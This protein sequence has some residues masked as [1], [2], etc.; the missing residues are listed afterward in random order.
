MMAVVGKKYAF[1]FM[2]SSLTHSLARRLVFE[3]RFKFIYKS[4]KFKIQDDIPNVN[5]VPNNVTICDKSYDGR[6][7]GSG[8]KESKNRSSF[9]LCVLLGCGWRNTFKNIERNRR[10]EG[11]REE[12]PAKNCNI[13][14]NSTTLDKVIVLIFQDD[15]ALVIAMICIVVL[16]C[17]IVVTKVC[18]LKISH[19][20]FHWN[21]IFRFMFWTLWQI[22]TFP[23]SVLWISKS[24]A[25]S[26]TMGM[27]IF[28]AMDLFPVSLHSCL[29]LN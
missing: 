28:L 4:V 5:S 9:Y 27:D 15:I 6:W 20:N 17:C 18:G 25:T 19:L 1:Q 10:R 22:Q 14:N 11:G 8:K 26:G 3:L 13:I 23:P 24:T 21:T 29:Q 12:A 2:L 7:T 16:T